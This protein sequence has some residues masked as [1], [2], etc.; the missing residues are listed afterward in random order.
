MTITQ[1]HL[2]VNFRIEAGCLGPEGPAHID[3]FCILAHKRLQALHSDFIDWNLTP[4]SDKTLPEID[5][6]I[7]GKMLS[8]AQ[9]A[10]YFTI[11]DQ[12]IE[13]FEAAVFEQ[14][15]IIIDQYF[16]R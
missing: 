13:D 11:F 8:R 1:T 9:A 12:H 3:Q 6:A 10:R 5:Y 2:T 7:S 15:P 4:R 16:S 14:L